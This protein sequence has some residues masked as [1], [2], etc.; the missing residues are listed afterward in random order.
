M[1]GE[2]RKYSLDFSEQTHG[3][4]H[5]Q[6]KKCGSMGGRLHPNTIPAPGCPQSSRHRAF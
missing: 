3:I 4:I 6:I 1:P 5:G 2:G